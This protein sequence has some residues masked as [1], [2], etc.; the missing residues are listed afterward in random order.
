MNSFNLKRF[1]TE[2]ISLEKKP[3]EKNK[4]LFYGNSYFAFWKDINKHFGDFFG[5][6]STKQSCWRYK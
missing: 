3:I 6:N 2:V 1:E 4:I 5:E